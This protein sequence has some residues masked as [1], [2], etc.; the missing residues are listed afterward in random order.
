MSEHTIDGQH[1]DLEMHIVH[2]GM[3][4]Y[5]GY[6]PGDVKYAAVGIMFSMDNYDEGID[7]ENIDVI[8]TFFDSLKW[9]EQR[10][11]P[12]VEE[13]QFGKLLMMLNTWDRWIYKGSV[14]TPPCDK[15]VYWNVLNTVYPIKK[16]Y[17]SLF[18]Q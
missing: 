15:F 7:V 14:T 12:R 1:M 2:E 16:K 3:K 11:N 8:D 4:D 6:H 10:T 5:K 9:I 13:V 18:E 17:I